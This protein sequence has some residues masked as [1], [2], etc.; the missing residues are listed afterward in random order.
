MPGYDN[1]GY[2]TVFSSVMESIRQDHAITNEALKGALRVFGL[3]Y[4]NHHSARRHAYAT[5][6][7]WDR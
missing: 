4:G 5:P 2:D 7:C 1:K 3:S 6:F